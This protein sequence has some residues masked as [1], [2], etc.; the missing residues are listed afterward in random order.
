MNFEM[1]NKKILCETRKQ[2]EILVCD[3]KNIR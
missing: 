2:Q 3:V 1:N